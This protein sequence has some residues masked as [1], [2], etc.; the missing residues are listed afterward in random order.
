MEKTVLSQDVPFA[1][2]SPLAFAVSENDRQTIAMVRDALRTGRLRLAYQPI[3]LAA[4]TNRIGFYEGL[5]RVL[6]P[7][8]RVIPARDFMGA[9]EAHEIGREI[10]CSALA[11]GLATLVSQPQL[12]L[13]VNMSARSIGYPK[14]TAIL[15]KAL[16]IHPGLGERLILEITESSAMLVPEIVVAFMDNL[17]A[18]G[19]AFAL[20]DF[21]AGFTAIRYLKDFSFDIMKIDGEYIRNI[22]SDAD[23]QV[24]AAAL[25]AIGKQ[26]DMLCVAESVETLADAEYLQ[27]LGVDCLQGYLFGAP[28]V[29][30]EWAVS[31]RKQRA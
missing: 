9:V 7:S 24:V 16:R 18:E 4:D 23:N 26:F 17:Q 30:P 29:R 2:A 5:M 1:E 3:V 27:A 8:G 13:A 11:M 31:G 22:H 14:W 25:L 20:D 6:D 12:R 19:I 28:T 15:R 10:D 21:G